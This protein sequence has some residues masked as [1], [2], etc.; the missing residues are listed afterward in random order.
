MHQNKVFQNFHKRGQHLMFNCW[1]HKRSRLGHWWFLYILTSRYL[2]LDAV[3]IKCSKTDPTQQPAQSPFTCV[4]SFVESNTWTNYGISWQ[5]KLCKAFDR[6]LESFHT[7]DFHL[8]YLTDKIFS[9][10]SS[11]WN[12]F[13]LPSKSKGWYYWS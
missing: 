6:I 9:L 5:T 2:R 8:S 11:N 4:K 3:K 12:D 7:T 10:W 1:T 13:N